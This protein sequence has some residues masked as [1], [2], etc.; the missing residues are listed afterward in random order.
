MVVGSHLWNSLTYEVHLMPT[1]LSIRRQA[2]MFLLTQDI[3]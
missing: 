1:L 2:Q 3:N